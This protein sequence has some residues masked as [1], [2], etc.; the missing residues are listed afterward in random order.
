MAGFPLDGALTREQLARAIE[1]ADK[2]RDERDRLV[3]VIWRML[4]P[5]E[6]RAAGFADMAAAIEKAMRGG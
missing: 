3:E 6:L 2:L 4:S 1:A 5:D